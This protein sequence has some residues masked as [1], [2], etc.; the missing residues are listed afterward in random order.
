MVNRTTFPPRPADDL[1][2][3]DRLFVC[4]AHWFF[5]K[6]YLFLVLLSSILFPH[7]FLIYPSQCVLPSPL[8]HLSNYPNVQAP[9]QHCSFMLLLSVVPDFISI[10][11]IYQGTVCNNNHLNESR[12]CYNC[13]F[14]KQIGSCASTQTKL[15]S[16]E[17]CCE[18]GHGSMCVICDYNAFRNIFNFE[19]SLTTEVV[20]FTHRKGVDDCVGGLSFG[21]YRFDP[22]PRIWAEF[23]TA[24]LNM[25]DKSNLLPKQASSNWASCLWSQLC[26]RQ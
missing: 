11:L 22:S 14:S 7:L 23:L 1:G 15:F 8:T 19:F 26:P 12:F 10:Y 17:M 5:V 6:L 20:A 18:E 2:I 4:F 24:V 9:T 3:F 16:S 21:G 13:C 25:T